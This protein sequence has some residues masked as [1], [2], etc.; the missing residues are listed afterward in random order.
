MKKILIVNGVGTCG[1]DTFARFLGK[2][3]EVYKMS[4]ID[5][6]K[7]MARPY[8]LDP[9]DKSERNRKMLCDLKNL[10]TEYNDLSFVTMADKVNLFMKDFIDGDV[11]LIDIREPKEIKR[12]K[13]KFNA[14]TLL[15]RRKDS[16]P[17]TSNFADANV[18]NYEYDYILENNGD[19]ED[20]DVAVKKY[21]EME[22][23]DD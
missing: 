6:I 4:S 10:W 15:I 17:I 3:V 1:K 9:D 11:M 20:F 12:A 23:K 2:Y 22:I 13:E 8:G 7:K 21:Y 5:I 18:E 16:P 19:L 14:K